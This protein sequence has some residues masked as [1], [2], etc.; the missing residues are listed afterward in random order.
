MISNESTGEKRAK[1]LVLK[2]KMHLFSNSDAKF[3]PLNPGKEPIKSRLVNHT[4]ASEKSS[5]LL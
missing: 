1:G 2:L 3:K 4:A 5:V